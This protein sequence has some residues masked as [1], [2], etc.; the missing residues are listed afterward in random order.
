VR[1]ALVLLGLTL[2]LA[3]CAALDPPKPRELTGPTDGYTP[4][5]AFLKLHLKREDGSTALL[6]FDRRD[7][8]TAK[9]AEM[10][11]LKQV[12]FVTA[13]A[14]PRNTLNEYLA[15]TIADPADVGKLRYDNMGVTPEQ[16]A[17][18]D[19]EYQRLLERYLETAPI[20]PSA[21]LPQDPIP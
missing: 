18:M 14:T 20:P 8:Y 4:T 7:W 2:F 3:G 1:G 9:I 15:E 11:D 16:R 21:L 12:K 17:D 6:D 19:N 13:Q 10:V 5:A